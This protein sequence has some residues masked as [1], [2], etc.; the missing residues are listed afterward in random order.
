M[1]SSKI[2]DFQT[3]P[4]PCPGASEFP[5]PPPPKTSA[6][7]F[8][9]IIFAHYFFQLWFLIIFSFNIK[10]TIIAQFQFLWSLKF[11]KYNYI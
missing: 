5:K 10:L 2:S 11:A 8:P 3:T 7:G 1:K 4:F 9:T 6:S